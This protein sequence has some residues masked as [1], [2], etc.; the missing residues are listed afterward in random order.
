MRKINFRFTYQFICLAFLTSSSITLFGKGQND[1]VTKA[2]SSK[3]RS[4]ASTPSSYLNQFW[5]P[6][7]FISPTS[8]NPGTFITGVTPNVTVS[9]LLTDTVNKVLS[10]QFGVNS[11]YRSG[12]TLN[13]RIPLYT[14]ANFGQFRFPAGS[15]SNA[16]FWD[17]IVPTDITNMDP[18]KILPIV[19]TNK[20]YFSPTQF[21]QFLAATGAQANIVVNYFYA[22][23]G[24]TAVNDQVG[25]TAAQ[26]R[27]AR[28]KQAADYA[29]G[30]VQKM[31]IDLKAKVLN[32]EIGNECYGNW[33]QGFNVNGLRNL[34][35]TEYGEDFK[36]FA[37]AMKA[38]DPT[39]KVGAVLDNSDVVW[40]SQ[41]LTQV[42]E[43][44][45]FLIIHEYFTPIN[46]STP[47][48]IL[49]SVGQ[50]KNDKDTINKWVVKYTGNASD[51]YPIALTEFNS[52]GTSSVTM[53]NGLFF[54]SILGEIIKNGYGFSTS[55]VNEWILEN[56]TSMGLISKADDVDQPQFTPRQAYMPYY[57]YGKYFGDYMVNSSTTDSGIDV[58][59]SVFSGGEAGIV[60]V[61]N[62]GKDQNVKI[63]MNTT[64]F[65]NKKAYWHEFYATDTI[66]GNKKFFINGQTGTSL[67]GGPTNYTSIPPY[68][69]PFKNNSIL[70]VKKF[71]VTYINLSL[72][73]LTDNTPLTE[74]Q[75]DINQFE[76]WP[77]PATSV[78][79]IHLHQDS[80]LPTPCEISDVN[81]RSVYKFT[82]NKNSITIPTTSLGAKGIYFI[83]IQSVIKKIVIN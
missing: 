28:V 32:W 49:A 61:N 72:D 71:S 57:F 45:D 76:I 55:W 58:Y 23:Y 56:N 24:K 77:N 39:I 26:I 59:S 60:I 52:R 62:K 25:A 47:A 31:N 11:N 78:I 80:K 73:L 48:S 18:S 17:G 69:A 16:Y 3:V 75:K 14:D 43:V 74:N 44:A 67:G 5:K 22:R 10:T 9:V 20:N 50:I 29:A 34:T 70:T 1:V 51:Y 30:F 7:T 15:G 82:M 81:G 19:G 41:V 21:S 37:T 4:I 79:N 6:R 68:S 13:T 2:S 40:S 46:T 54:S 66:A 12:S 63:N 38:I 83:A 36:V 42:K 65:N 33:E 27:T 53:V 35:G 8:S 64:K